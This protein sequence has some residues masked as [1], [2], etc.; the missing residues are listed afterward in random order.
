M[1]FAKPGGDCFNAFAHSRR[2]RILRLL[3][4]HPEVGQSLAAMQKAT[5]YKAAPLLKHLRIMERAGL[6]A[7]DPAGQA[8]AGALTPGLRFGAVAKPACERRVA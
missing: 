4:E 5:G 2:L 8:V 1:P 6:I 7:R 3:A